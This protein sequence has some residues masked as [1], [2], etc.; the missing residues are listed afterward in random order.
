MKILIKNDLFDISS[1]L[2][3][4]DPSYEV[5][6]ETE[7]QKFTL[8]ARG[9][10]QLVFPF[11]NLDA[12]A[13]THTRKT[14]VERIDELI[15]EIDLGNEKYQNGRLSKVKDKFEDELSRRL[16]LAKL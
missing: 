4:I 1:R 7:L 9:K 16:R 10:R 2:K 3:E 8:W 14:R 6:F 13:L 5:Y 15:K 11:E 12:R